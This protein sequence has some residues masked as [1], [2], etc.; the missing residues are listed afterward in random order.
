MNGCRCDT[1]KGEFFLNVT[2]NSAATKHFKDC[3]CRVIFKESKY[4][5]VASLLH[6]EH[7]MIMHRTKTTTAQVGDSVS[8]RNFK[9]R[10]ELLRRGS[11]I[12]ASRHSVLLHVRRCSEPLNPELL[13][14]RMGSNTDFSGH[15]KKQRQ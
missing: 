4:C 14:R 11:T 15:Q 6:R 10:D 3:G 9:S 1:F 2:G 8:L 5:N 13:P 7:S 12:S